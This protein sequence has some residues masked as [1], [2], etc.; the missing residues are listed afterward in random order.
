MTD[1]VEI[2]SIKAVI[3]IIQNQLDRAEKL[4]LYGLSIDNSNFDIIYDLAFLYQQKG[5]FER[6]KEL[7]TLALNYVDS[8]QMKEQII[9]NITFLD[10]NVLLNKK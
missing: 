7:Y 3:Y 4:L 6:A 8:E 2:I 5:D 10:Q 9:E 1:D